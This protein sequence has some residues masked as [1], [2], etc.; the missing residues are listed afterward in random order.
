M[1]MLSQTPEFAKVDE[2]EVKFPGNNFD[3]VIDVIQVTKLKKP[4]EIFFL[5]VFFM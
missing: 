4:Q 2:E 5:P 1:K 3:E